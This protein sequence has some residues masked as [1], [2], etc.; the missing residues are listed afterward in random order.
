VK[1]VISP[2][3]STVSA[4][5]IFSLSLSGV[6]T[7]SAALADTQPA[8][9][10]SPAATSTSAPIT[11]SAKHAA[12]VADIAAYKAAVTAAIQGRDLARADAEATLNQALS[13]AGKDKAARKSAWQTYKSAIAAINSAY[14]DALAAAKANLPSAHQ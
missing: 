11:S 6:C 10:A 8:P 4:V 1:K 12:R 13:A 9:S 14:Q 3:A 7:A 2:R 5:L